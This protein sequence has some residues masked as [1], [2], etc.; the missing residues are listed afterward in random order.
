MS[1][2]LNSRYSFFQLVRLVERAHPDS[3][4]IGQLGPVARESVRFR[5]APDLAF[6]T[7]DITDV[8]T[9]GNR[10]FVTTSFLGLTGPTTPL[11]TCYAE[12]VVR[13]D[14]THD[15]SLAAFYDVFH[16]RILALIYRT[17]S[18]YRP[19]AQFRA[20]G[21]DP[22]TQRALSLIGVAP[23]SPVA[24]GSLPSFDQLALAPILVGRVRSGRALELVLR[25]VF[26]GI[27][28]AIEPFV[29][30]QVVFDPVERVKL[31]QSHTTLGLDFTIGR[32]VRD[33]SGRFRVRV[34]PV[35][36]ETSE[37]FLPGGPDFPRLRGIVD[38]FTRG[39]LEAEVEIELDASASPRF[40][41]AR[42]TGARLGVTTR[43]GRREHGR[44][45]LRVLLS[46]DMADV[47]PTIVSS[48]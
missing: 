6:A 44:T 13:N 21:K 37:R 7:S 18:K 23:D 19:M 1:N 48:T 3:A 31:G 27:T 29:D 34:G 24:Q 15:G 25:R 42:G 35:D 33:R 9:V 17:W 14:D 20:D 16:H 8:T 43:I 12:D 30:R 47:R 5:N 45:K 32:A 2:E 10:T 41:I 39:V 4:P 38:H 36:H 28:I 40:C 11:A 46:D 22:F 26:P